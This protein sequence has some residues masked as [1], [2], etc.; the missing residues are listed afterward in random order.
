MPR[1]HVEMRRHATTRMIPQHIG[2]HRRHLSAVA[3]DHRDAHP[4][5]REDLAEEL[6]IDG[7]RT[8]L[9]PGHRRLSHAEARRQIT[10]AQ[11]ANAPHAHDEP[12]HLDADRGILTLTPLLSFHAPSL[13][14]TTDLRRLEPATTFEPRDSDTD[15]PGGSVSESE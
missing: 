4:G 5:D 8:G 2:R 9:Q 15:P 1:T 3:I 10:L 14:A 7:L 6:D 11:V 12:R 13:Q